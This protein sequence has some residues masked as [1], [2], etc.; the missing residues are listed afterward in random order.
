M[1]HWHQ[2]LNARDCSAILF[3]IISTTHNTTHTSMKYQQDIKR[4][5]G[6]YI[7]I[8]IMNPPGKMIK[9]DGNKY[10]SVD[11]GFSPHAASH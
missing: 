2:K 4:L 9:G 3:L 7:P 8:S 1:M 6:L 11:F 5:P 10:N